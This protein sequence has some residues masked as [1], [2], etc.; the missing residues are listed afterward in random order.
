MK[1]GSD[2][3]GLSPMT[4][5]NLAKLYAW[6]TFGVCGAVASGVLLIQSL[7]GRLDHHALGQCVISWANS[8]AFAGFDTW[9]RFG[10][11]QERN[12]TRGGSQV[13]VSTREQGDSHLALA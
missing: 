6:L 13:T 2:M 1:V 10:R 11:N 5:K 3:E 7:V 12:R 8:L 9:K 4:W